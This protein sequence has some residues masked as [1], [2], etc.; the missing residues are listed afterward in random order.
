MDDA[1]AM[2]DDAY[3]A[4]VETG[5]ERLA[6][7]TRSD[8]G[9]ALRIAGDLGSAEA[10]YRQTIHGWE[11]RGE[12]GAIANQFESFAFIAIKRGDLTRAAT[13]LGAAE[14]LREASGAHM[15]VLE[16][17]IYDAAVADLRAR[18][19]P[20][21]LTSAWTAGRSMSV[22]AAVL[23]ATGDPPIP[24]GEAASEPTSR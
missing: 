9:H 18:L 23:L 24:A 1:R 17:R 2:F 6:L 14:S 19:D 22:P 13:L 15:V 8:L 12:R 10:I 4:Y 7:A 20:D 3:A 21:A 5:D 16:Q 11:D